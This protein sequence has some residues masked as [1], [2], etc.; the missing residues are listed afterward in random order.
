[1][2][3]RPM[4]HA[5]VPE[6]DVITADAF[7]EIDVATRPA[8]WPEPQRRD[9]ERAALWRRRME[10]LVTH[11]GPGCWVADDDSGR[12]VGAVAALKREGFWGL[13][14]YA[15]RP[16]LQAK[17]IG[18]QLLDAAL[19]YADPGGRGFICSSHDP[20][21]VRRYALAG[22][23]MHPTALIWGSPRRDTLPAGTGTRQGGPDDLPLMERSDRA[24]RGASHGVD[25]E[26][27]LDQ[28]RVV[29]IDEGERFG[30]A[31]L[32]ASGRPYLLAASDDETAG[33]LL[34]EALAST[35]EGAPIDLGHL[36]ARHQWAI[37]I[38]L[39]AGMEVHNRGYLALRGME[40]PSAYLPSGHF[41]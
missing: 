36:T 28:Y 18:K 35:T 7:Y 16:G 34:W 10:H 23:Q 21:A 13:S 17:G 3:I 37:T 5:D 24:T 15:V 20:R 40:P 19:T 14:T 1:M 4:T 30:Y 32:Y 9:P 2:V 31:Y 12:I 8:D 39:H 38:G 11:D 33:R 27:M 41:L 26:L 29:V 25:H 22:F 6:V